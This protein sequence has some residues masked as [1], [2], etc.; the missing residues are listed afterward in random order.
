M[1]TAP[2]TAASR[3][4]AHLDAIGSGMA[5]PRV[6][7][8]TDGGGAWGWHL[9][10]GTSYPSL[11]SP[12]SS[13]KSRSCR[14]CSGC[15]AARG[16]AWS[17]VVAYIA[18]RERSVTS[19]IWPVPCCW[20]TQSMPAWLIRHAQ[21]R[22]RGA[23]NVNDCERRNSRHCARLVFGIAGLFR[24]PHCASRA[25]TSESRDYRESSSGFGHR[26]PH[27]SED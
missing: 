24:N 15:A 22:E 8:H 10:V 13:R 19:I 20:A 18:P 9:K 5:A 1:V 17:R 7:G 16:D 25:T 14:R 11:P 26:Y 2:Q 3:C 4:R 23:I 21:N 27:P 12:A 6:G